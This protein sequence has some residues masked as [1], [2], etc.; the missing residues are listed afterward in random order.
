MAETVVVDGVMYRRVPD[1]SNR[2][3]VV[4]D[5]GWI[6]AGDL[7]EKDG[8]ILLGR[9][10]WLFRWESVGFAK[11][12]EG[13]KA[14]GADLRHHADVSIPA[15]AEIFRVPVAPEWGLSCAK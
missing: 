15:G 8:R 12:I 5:R 6:F 13:P 3:V 4:V 7:E 2:C 10:V 1:F 11:V 9:V 14:S